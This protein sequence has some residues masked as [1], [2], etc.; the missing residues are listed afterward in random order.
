MPERVDRGLRCPQLG[1]PPGCLPCRAGRWAYPFTGTAVRGHLRCDVSA[2]KSAAELD[3]QHNIRVGP[4][5][6]FCLV[7]KGDKPVVRKEV[8][9][10]IQRIGCLGGD[11]FSPLSHRLLPCSASAAAT[12]GDSS[13]RPLR[14]SLL[15][16]LANAAA[17]S[18]VILFRPLM[19]S[20]PRAWPT[21]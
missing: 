6:C 10:L 21:P 12:S 8:L 7:R 13:I 19:C 17:T 16:C 1:S 11:F 2:R 3:P 9:V 5:R 20:D 14:N 15:S 18:G 4:Q